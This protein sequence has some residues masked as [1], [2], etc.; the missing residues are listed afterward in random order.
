MRKWD[1]SADALKSLLNK[2]FVY[3]E[4]PRLSRHAIRNISRK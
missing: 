4:S 3:G 1:K 2:D